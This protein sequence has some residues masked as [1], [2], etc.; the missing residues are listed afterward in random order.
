MGAE[1]KLEALKAQHKR[2]TKK[3]NKLQEFEE[4]LKKVQNKYSDEFSDLAEID[5]RYRRL[6]ETNRLL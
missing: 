3:M 5:T 1:A 4:F 6:S 2:I